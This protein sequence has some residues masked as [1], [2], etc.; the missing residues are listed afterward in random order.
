MKS[1][2]NIVIVGGGACSLMLG[3]E[4]NPSIFNVSVYD[5]NVAVGR[6]FLVAGAGG[7]NITHSKKPNEFI[8]MYT[9]NKF[10]ID[11][12]NSFNNIDLQ[13]WLK[14]KLNI[15]T[16]VGTSGKVFPTKEIKPIEVLNAFINKSK[17]NNVNFHNKHTWLGFKKT[18]YYLKKKIL[19]F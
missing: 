10:L 9:P 2:I 18:H 4:L 6:K 3:C 12:F 7:L 17:L 1:K 15:S 19:K 8:E 14:N 13:H 11:A 16:Y 5:A